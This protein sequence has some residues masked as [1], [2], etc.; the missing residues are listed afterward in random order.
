MKLTWLRE[1][2]RVC[3][4][5][6]VCGRVGKGAD[7]RR[8]FTTRRFSSGG[9]FSA[10]SVWK[11]QSEAWRTHWVSEERSNNMAA[12]TSK[13]APWGVMGAMIVVACARVCHA[14]DNGAALTPPMGWSSWNAFHCGISHAKLL[15]VADAMD[16]SG[17]IAAGYSSLNVD[18][19]MVLEKR[20]DDGK[21]VVD[22]AKFPFGMRNFSDEVGLHGLKLGVYTAHG[23]ETCQKRAGSLG[24][25]AD[26]AASYLSWNVSFLKN[27]WCWHNE[28]NQTIH[29]SAFNAMRDALAAAGASTPITYSIHWNTN[30]V[31]GPGCVEGANCP[32]PETANMWRIGNDISP[33]WSSI[34][35]LIDLDPGHEAA[36]G[37]GSYNDADMLEVGNGMTENQDRAHFTMWC[38]LASPLIA[39]NDVR[40]MSQKTVG[41]VGRNCASIVFVHV[42][43]LAF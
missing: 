6:C 4:C 19:C 42:V 26:D 24:H 40:S 7:F 35:R 31:P 43:A 12:V 29:L 3:V 34:L 18:D 21:L 10:E 36:A 41:C 39:G 2:V 13:S 30:D 28:P 27:D 22:P 20:S 14:L 25:E 38:M 33:K 16:E 9:G 32:L 11:E 23:N 1:A 15:Q 5:V 8:F 37:R 17:M